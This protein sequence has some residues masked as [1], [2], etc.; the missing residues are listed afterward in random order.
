M[1][2]PLN[3]TTKRVVTLALKLHSLQAQIVNHPARFKVV[4]CGRRWGKTR[5]GGYVAIREALKG[6]RIWWVAPILDTAK[7]AWRLIKT[8]V[9]KIPG[10][11]IREKVLYFPGGGE[12]WFKSADN[13]DSLR[14]EGIDGLVIDEADYIPG[15]VW[16]KIL[17]PMLADRKGWAFFISTPH[18]QNGYFHELYK[19]GQADGESWASW[20]YPSWTNPYLDP[21]EIEDAKGDMSELEFDQEFG[22]KFVG[23]PDNVY[24]NFNSELHVKPC[25]L[26][27]S[28]PVWPGVDFNNSPRVVA[29]LQ[30]DPLTKIVK[31]VGEV[32]HPTQLT[33]D[34]HAELAA[35]WLEERHIKR[36]DDQFD[37]EKVKCCPDATGNARQRTG[38]SD[39]QAFKDAG[40]TLNVAKT[41][42]LKIDRDNLVLAYLK[43]KKGEIRIQIDPSC[44][45]LIEAFGKLK[46]KG[47]DTSHY[48]HILDAFGYA[49][50]RMIKGDT[51]IPELPESAYEDLY[52]TRY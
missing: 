45:N 13:P 24:H 32:F 22:A 2:A 33:S 11:L 28:L 16:S 43:N 23:A 9:R 15:D 46:H 30:Q 48:S 35:R 51:S 39:H 6:K 10:A 25:F 4:V 36:W 3:L 18:E 31:A 21:K 38:K 12:I 50:W 7:I 49:L 29:F 34:E 8:L 41:N 42:P 20:S 19:K 37:P 27:P 47:R 44:K 26:N 52:S 14:G 5:V 17:R 1:S 40:F